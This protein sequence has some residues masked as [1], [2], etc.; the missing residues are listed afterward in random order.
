[1]TLKTKG[2][3]KNTLHTYTEQI[4]SQI[5]LLLLLPITLYW[6]YIGTT[7]TLLTALLLL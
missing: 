5:I 1:M 6:L 7:T 3:E 2:T 4:R